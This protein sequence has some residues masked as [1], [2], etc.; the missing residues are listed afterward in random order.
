MSENWHLLREKKISSHAP[1]TGSWYLLKVLFKISD[2]QPRPFYMEGWGWGK[3]LT[4][5]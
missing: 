3:E 5:W 1:K 4:C 2:E